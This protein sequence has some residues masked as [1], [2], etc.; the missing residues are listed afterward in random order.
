MAPTATL[1]SFQAELTR[2]GAHFQRDLSH[3]ES[4]T[5]NEASLRQQFLDPLFRSL[6]WDVGNLKG[7]IHT[8]RE[9]D[10]EVSTP[11]AGTKTRADYVFRVNRIE[12]FTCEAKKPSEILHNGHIYQAKRDAWARGIPFAILSDFEELKVYV[13]SSRP[14]RDNPKEGEYL[15]LHHSQYLGAARQLWDLLAYDNVAGGCLDRL[16]EA[17]P[18]R[19]L[20]G[21]AKQGWLFRPERTQSLDAE[22]LNL[23]DDNRQRLGSDLLK[24]N[25]RDDLL[26]GN[27]LNE[28]AQRIIDRLVFLRICEDRGIDTGTLLTSILSGWW[29]ERAATERPRLNRGDLDRRES[30]PDL[31]LTK[32]RPRTLD[33]EPPAPRYAPPA[34]GSLYR[35]LVSHIRALD[36]RPPN[37]KPFFNGQLFKPH[38]SEDLVVGDEWLAN[39]LDDLTDHDNGYNF[40]D[41]KVEILG[42]AYERFLGKVL[43]P[44]GRGATI[45]EK[46]EVRKAGGVYYTPRYI[47]DYIVE[48]TVGRQ[49]EG[50]T[51]AQ[52]A[53]L[54][55]LDPACGSGS[56]LI[57]V[58]ERVMEHYLRVFTERVREFAERAKLTNEPLDKLLRPHRDDYYLDAA[59]NVRLTTRLKRQILQNNVFGTDID[60]QAVE[61]TQLSLYLKML[62]GENRES[63]HLQSNDLFSKEALLPALDQNIKCGNSLIAS[64]FSLDPAE[65]VRVNAFD[66]DIGFEKIMAKG[67]FDAVV[68]NPPYIPIETMAASERAYY[69]TK[70][71]ELERKFDTSVAFILAGINLC[72]SSGLLGYISST[73]W[74]TGENY[75]KLRQTIFQKHGLL[76]LV[77]L[78]F[79][80]FDAAYVETCVYIIGRKPSLTYKIANLPKKIR[81]SS[82]SGIKLTEVTCSLVQSPDYRVILNPAAESLG[83]RLLDASMFVPLGEITKSTQGLAASCFER[84]PDK[85]AG[86][87]WYPFGEKC[88]AFRHAFILEETSYADMSERP[89]LKQ[90]YDAVPKVLI[91]RVINRQ[92]RLDVAYVDKCMV[93]KKDLNPFIPTVSGYDAKA[94]ASILNSQLISYLYI[95]SSAIATKD[96]FRQTT[97]AEL[98]R[99]PIPRAVTQTDTNKALSGLADKSRT[100]REALN[101]NLSDT[102]RAALQNAIR[103]TDRDI[104]K[105]VYELYGL[106]PEEIALVEGTAETPDAEPAATEA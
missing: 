40:A 48:Q 30:Q 52:A 8:E 57:R 55:F 97:L 46:P 58:Y 56:F 28:A 79:D 29:R 14:S 83:R 23:L 90:F 2:L 35:I 101:S 68:G 75:G 91:R 27:H 67:G 76:E 12:R 43:R 77:N 42:S 65:L 11:T 18:K 94:L 31:P 26:A 92:D 69:Q 70:Y 13:V 33:D 82:L 93:F 3:F 16:I 96:D 17:L 36:Q 64:D 73:T 38:F 81:L 103:K 4:G 78:P 21:R 88:Q 20:R 50:K 25:D 98:R 104:D 84:R 41:I 37:Y 95:N 59:A 63:L 34:D 1:E 53:K 9:V 24:N 100:L 32:G 45:E 5:Y 106:T 74:E 54:R 87:N 85:P 15:T 72:G 51:P 39:F 60:A 6:G 7:L 19:T 80:I 89:S 105:L 22:F 99:L 86:L 71:P 66:W 49:L 10:I 44:Q 62:E 102:E 61:V 47:V